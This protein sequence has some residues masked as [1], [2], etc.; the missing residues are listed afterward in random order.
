MITRNDLKKT[1]KKYRIKN[2]SEIKLKYSEKNHRHNVNEINNF[3]NSLPANGGNADTI[4]NVHINNIARYYKNNGNVDITDTNIKQFYGTC[5]TQNNSAPNTDWWHIINVPHQDD[6]GYGA[7]IALG[8][9]GQQNLQIRSASGTSWGAW[10]DVI[11]NIENLKSTVVNGK[12]SVANAI[13]DK[14]GTSLSNQSSFSEMASAIAGIKKSP[15]IFSMGTQKI[16]GNSSH[17]LGRYIESCFKYNTGRTGTI[18]IIIQPLQD[19]GDLIIHLASGSYSNL[20]VNQKLST[21]SMENN[22]YVVRENFSGYLEMNLSTANVNDIGRGIMYAY[23]I[24]Y[25]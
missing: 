2:D 21:I 5:V 25:N 9:H 10:Y 11:G 13:N 1:L 12:Q 18:E 4:G 19:I 15:N 8:Y 14:A 20:I 16:T 17:P 24:Y 23:N 3:P 22:C 6:N 7:Q